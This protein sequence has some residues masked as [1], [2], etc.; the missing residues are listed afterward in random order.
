[1]QVTGRSL[2]L[3]LPVVALAGCLAPLAGLY[4][5]AANE[6]PTPVYV[7]THGWHT[8]IGVRAADVPSHLWPARDDF[9]RA[10]YLEIGWGNRDYWLAARVTW[11]VV[12]NATLRP[13]PSALR[14]IEV[15]R[16][17][18]EFFLESDIVEIGLSRRGFERLITFIH[19]SYATR[20]SGAAI[21][22]GPGPLPN[23]RYY[24]AKGNYHV[25]NTS[26][27]WTAKALRAAG[28]P[29]TPGYALSV[30]T[31]ICQ[32]TRFGRIL[33][34]RDPVSSLQACGSA[35]TEPRLGRLDETPPTGRRLA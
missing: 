16:P 5:P 31:V 14:V 13:T 33:R 25:F 23:S 21:P 17:I 3:F 18:E 20:E 6:P 9:P 7:V 1:M 30:G 27:K 24:L 15:D 2:L 10:E 32:T 4:P 26:N 8:G 28:F 12:L 19:E 29:I 35:P 34:A 11:G 22:L